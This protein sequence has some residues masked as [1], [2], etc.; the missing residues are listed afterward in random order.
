M[1]VQIKN[2]FN[3]I[4]TTIKD[5]EE[6]T[7]K[8]ISNHESVLS[9]KNKQIE[10][11]NSINEKQKSEMDDFL[12]VSYAKRWK[13]SAEEL[14]KKNIH[15]Q[16]KLESLTN[17]NEKLNSKLDALTELVSKET[18]TNSVDTNDYD[19]NKEIKIKTQKG[20]IYTLVNGKLLGKD[21][22]LVGEVCQ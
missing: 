15:L 7:N 11:L 14:E 19:E 10:I 9:D 2:L 21:N 18:Q 6:R 17:T 22:K 12:K 16:E 1:E 8:Q 13:N 3:S 20:A 5:Y 4:L